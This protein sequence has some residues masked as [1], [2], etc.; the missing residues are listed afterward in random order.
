MPGVRRAL[1]RRPGERRLPRPVGAIVGA[2]ASRRVTPRP[3]GR[4]LRSGRHAARLR[5]A[6]V[7]A[8]VRCGV[9]A[10]TVTFGHVITDEC[11]RL[12]IALDDYIAAYDPQRACSLSTASSICSRRRPVGRRV[13][14]RPRHG[15]GRIG[16]V[17]LA[18]R[19]G[20]LRAGLRRRQAPRRGSRRSRDRERRR[21][22]S[23]ATPATTATLLSP[24]A[25]RFV[26]AGWNRRADDPRRRRRRP[27]SQRHHRPALALTTLALA[28]RRRG[29]TRGRRNGPSADHH[30]GRLA[31][32][33]RPLVVRPAFSPRSDA[34][35]RRLARRLAGGL[36]AGAGG[37]S[38]PR[39]G[40]DRGNARRH[41]GDGGLQ[42]LG[43]LLRRRRRRHRASHR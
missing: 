11:E 29:R 9:A 22:S 34:A 31:A 41:F 21:C 43:D 17:W 19:G 35:D 1:G 25:L 15:T 5:R 37:A 40:R 20:L 26:V 23:S 28:L 24:P 7:Q 38:I 39:H 3:E 10:E 2:G 4:D 13:A 8:F 16:R 42:L 6:L 33:R 32:L 14:Q 18:S 30:A 27:A 36:L 12:G